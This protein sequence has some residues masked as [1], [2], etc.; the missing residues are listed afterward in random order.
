MKKIAFTYSS[1]ICMILLT[2]CVLYMHGGAWRVC[3][4]FSSVQK[5]VEKRPSFL[6]MYLATAVAKLSKRENSQVFVMFR[7]EIPFYF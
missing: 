3:R 1:S 7:I 6:E 5:E 2:S 4:A